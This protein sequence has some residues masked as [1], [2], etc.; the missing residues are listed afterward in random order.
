MRRDKFLSLSLCSILLLGALPHNAG[1]AT[2]W[3]PNVGTSSSQFLRV[4]DALNTRSF[5]V[6]FDC[7]ALGWG[8]ITRIEYENVTVSGTSAH[9]VRANGIQPTYRQSV[10][11]ASGIASTTWPSTIY[12]GDATK[13]TVTF[14]WTWVSGAVVTNIAQDDIT[15]ASS[16]KPHANVVYAGATGSGFGGAYLP[17]MYVYGEYATA[18]AAVGGSSGTSTTITVADPVLGGLFFI[19]LI[20]LIFYTSS[21]W[22]D[23][24][25]IITLQRP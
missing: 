19:F 9:Q 11:T 15:G 25:R 13:S 16:I 4:G 3:S 2:L 17:A 7:A 18:T 6:T 10:T 24:F 1:A 20:F 8:E 23:L 14:A 22:I 12:C 21:W 5:Y